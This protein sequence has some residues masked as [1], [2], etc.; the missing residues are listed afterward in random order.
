LQL[1]YGG[2]QLRH[3]SADVRELYYVGLGVQCKLAELGEVVGDALRVREILGEI[4]YYATGQRDVAG[5][6]FYTGAFGEGADY[7]QK[8]IGG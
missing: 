2:S 4:S 1:L 6:H 8:G 7:R 3:G 5:L